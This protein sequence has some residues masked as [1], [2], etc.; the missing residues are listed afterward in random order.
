MR[1]S[2]NQ[3]FRSG[4]MGILVTISNATNRNVGATSEI[5][6]PNEVCGACRTLPTAEVVNP[7]V[8]AARQ[9][10]LSQRSFSSFFSY[11][12]HFPF[13]GSWSILI[14]FDGGIASHV[15]KLTLLL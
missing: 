3:K 1:R 15:Q 12:V 4:S 14:Q 5:P 10:F 2:L 7:K 8:V 9:I 13:Q 6:I 11:I